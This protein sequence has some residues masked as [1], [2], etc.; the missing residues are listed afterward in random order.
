VAVRIAR[1]YE[2][3][4]AAWDAF[5]ENAVNSTFLHTR[6]FYNHNSENL[7][8]DCS[9][10]FYDDNEL[11]AVLPA[12]IYDKS[13]MRILHSYLRSTYGGVIM[14]QGVKTTDIIQCL[15]LLDDEAKHLQVNEI[16]IRQPFSIYNNAQ[17]GSIDYALWKTGFGIKYRE[18]EFAIDLSMP[19]QYNS[20]TQRSVKAAAKKGVTVAENTQIDVYWQIL[21]DNLQ[22]RYGVKPVHSF[23]DIILLMQNVGAEKVKLFAAFVGEKMIGGILCFITNKQ[24]IHAQYIASVNEYQEYRPL[25]AVI[26]HIAIWAAENGYKYFNLGMA[27][28]PGGEVINEGLMRFKEG[29]GAQ[30]V[31]RETMH[32]LL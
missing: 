17:T 25:N 3:D 30:G 14:K 27:T 28:E 26:H 12:N 31:L 19:L 5:V 21:T 24:S 10:M 6:G 32:K 7:K 18:V 29:F 22:E 8:D 4:G 13:N 16:I 11:I 23:E 15:Q 1:Y 9:F 20:S 2:V